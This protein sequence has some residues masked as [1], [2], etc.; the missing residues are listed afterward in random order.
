[1][2]PAPYYLVLFQQET[3]W[4]VILSPDP[5]LDWQ[6]S[7]NQG[8]DRVW[9]WDRPF[10]LWLAER[11]Q[12]KLRL[13]T[14][15][16]K[17]GFSRHRGGRVLNKTARS[18]GEVGEGTW[19]RLTVEMFPCS[20]P[21]AAAAQAGESS[22]RLQALLP[23]LLPG[24]SLTLSELRRV[25]ER[26]GVRSTDYQL[27]GVLQQ[28]ILEGKVQR[29]AAVGLDKLGRFYC[30]RCGEQEQIYVERLS[31]APQPCRVCPSCREMGTLTDGIPLYRWRVELPRIKPSGVPP[32]LALPALT[33]WQEQAVRESLEFWRQ[34]EPRTLLVWAVCG[35][36][37][38]EVVFPLIR[39]ALAAGKRILLAVPRRE[40]V[41]ELGERIK[42]CF[43]GLAFTILYGGHKEEFPAA[44]LTV[45]TTHQ[46]LRFTSCFDLVIVDEADA[47]PLYGNP[48][49]NAA[50]ERVILPTGKKIY[51]TATPDPSWQRRARRGEIG[52]VKI[53]LRYHGRP[54]PVPTLIRTAL[55]AKKGEFIPPV[56][57]EFI[58][59]LRTQER[60]GL[61][62]LPTVQGVEA[63]A[64]SLQQE[65]PNQA[66]QIDYIH[67]RDPLR[68]EKV[69]RFSTGQLHLLVTTTLLERGLNFDH[70]D[71]LVLYADQ[72]RI[73]SVETLIQIAGRVG[74]S[75]A[76]PGGVVYFVA[77]SITGTMKTAHQEIVRMNKEGNSFIKKKAT[78]PDRE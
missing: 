31:S 18:H 8:Y 40:I 12:E 9:V 66:D 16:G 14:V 78:S 76:D 15:K 47:F 63:F 6:W 27:T 68:E 73:F 64:R 30:R 75:A 2:L 56:V 61:I 23:K 25:L 34:P 46:L 4:E 20:L 22:C 26:A 37:K 7:V 45:T 28:L 69:K 38:T 55:P 3:G 59:R 43:H 48:M 42:R 65:L 60:K 77:E 11:M 19:Q 54:L 21:A 53:P 39:D 1:M 67:A 71:L 32:P 33:I 17:A 52:V 41:R 62:F 74:R 5:A 51:M 10:P 58:F 24:R 36:G 72:E 70:L 44:L 57:K 35:A 50:L 49:L 29:L 13:L